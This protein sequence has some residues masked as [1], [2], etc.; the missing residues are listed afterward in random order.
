MRSEDEADGVTVPPEVLG[1]A[2]AALVL[3][4][5]DTLVILCRDVEE[6][7]QLEEVSERFRGQ[8]PELA[9]RTVLVGSAE[10]LAVLR[11]EVSA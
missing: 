3:R 6:P 11:G 2:R 9:K 1:D 7:S 8:F 10:Q 5:G 4:P